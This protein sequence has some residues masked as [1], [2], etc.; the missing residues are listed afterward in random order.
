MLVELVEEGFH[1]TISAKVWQIILCC[2]DKRI[3]FMSYWVDKKYCH[4]FV[5]CL[6]Y[7]CHVVVVVQYCLLLD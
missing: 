2:I 6:Q 3:H 7:E 5:E 4:S 1:Y